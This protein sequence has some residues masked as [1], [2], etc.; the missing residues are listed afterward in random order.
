MNGK[1]SVEKDGKITIHEFHDNALKR[2]TI[3][4]VQNN[5]EEKP[6][7]H[8]FYLIYSQGEAFGFLNKPNDLK[9]AKCGL[10]AIAET[11]SRSTTKIV[12]GVDDLN[13]NKSNTVY[14]VLDNRYLNKG[15]HLYCDFITY[16]LVVEEKLQEMIEGS[17]YKL[18]CENVFDMDRIRSGKILEIKRS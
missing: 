10:E 12:C 4:I 8:V 16:Y 14:L 6:I 2:V 18:N 3:K 7:I 15:D 9:K 11:Y 17:L 5:L 1:W 13:L